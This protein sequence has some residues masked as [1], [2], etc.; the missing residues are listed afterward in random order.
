M[1][2]LGGMPSARVSLDS[3]L[4]P[5]A[6]GEEP[7]LP[8]YPLGGATMPL[9]QPA[10][11][12]LA[13]PPAPAPAPLPQYS[14]SALFG[15]QPAAPPQAFPLSTPLAAPPPQPLY[16]SAFST[17]SPAPAPYA[18]PAYA[19]L[20]QSPFPSLP[21]QQQ[22]PLRQQ[23]QPLQ[24]QQ[25]PQLQQKQQQQQQPQQPVDLLQMIK[26][27]PGATPQPASPEPVDLL[28]LIR[29]SPDVPQQQQQQ[30]R[31]E[32]P[33]MPPL[34]TEDEA[35]VVEEGQRDERGMIF[36][37]QE[38]EHEE[39]EEEEEEDENAELEGP[40][41]MAVLAELGRK[42]QQQRNL[43]APF[44]IPEREQYLYR[45][46]TKR[47]SAA[48]LEQIRDAH[49]A[50]MSTDTPY[51][52]D[53]YY[54]N[55]V[56]QRACE[57]QARDGAAPLDRETQ[58]RVHYYFT[59][60]PTADCV[61]R[62]FPRETSGVPYILGKVAPSQPRKPKQVVQL[63]ALEHDQL[64][65]VDYL[66]ALR[67]AD[68]ERLR[69]HDVLDTGGL[70]LGDVADID[71]LVY[72]AV[73]QNNEMYPRATDE[74]RAE[75]IQ[76]VLTRYRRQRAA[77]C[78]CVHRL[79]E[80]HRALLARRLRE[81]DVA[82]FLSRA[83]MLLPRIAH[84]RAVALLFLERL[85]AL[86]DLV[87][88]LDPADTAVVQH[89]DDLLD[90]LIKFSDACADS[91]AP[92][93]DTAPCVLPALTLPALDYVLRSGS[94]KAAPAM[95]FTL[96]A[97]T[98]ARSPAFAAAPLCDLLSKLPS[99]VSASGASASGAS[100]PIYDSSRLW[101]IFDVVVSKDPSASRQVFLTIKT[102]LTAG[103][104]RP[105]KIDRHCLSVYEK[106]QQKQKQQQQQQQQ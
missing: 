91:R 23:P 19:P 82:L 10:Y 51:V 68:G 2:T 28:Q 85:P 65:E 83:F 26:Q 78:A 52:D 5:A 17:L 76:P 99:C 96:L 55:Y 104:L 36:D 33:K 101:N 3:A 93:P 87:R 43:F 102:L 42:K 35:L 105:I 56:V 58:A 22:Q 47:M 80:D 59:H 41:S 20:G 38:E 1:G 79:V 57:A 15:S 106:L 40:P 67:V 16:S 81:R 95:L 77:C 24:Q 46:G 66:G 50:Q 72:Y 21:L 71:R 29:S 39:E 75:I 69:L 97:N 94:P 31:F 27:S 62:G 8:F 4:F 64:Y 92:L 7:A 88:G 44:M 84:K 89:V 73:Q 45:T 25:Q 48:E 54:V 18:P 37:G 11:A 30:Q 32:E 98:L 9:G 61:G 14:F 63:L 103:L 6:G 86:V 13:M 90:S 74:Q 49:Y 53:Y 100:A 70:W 34:P 12:P 60:Q